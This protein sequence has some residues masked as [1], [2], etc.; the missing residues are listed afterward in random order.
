M[1]LNFKSVSILSLVLMGASAVTAAIIP[2]KPADLRVQGSISQAGTDANVLTCTPTAQINDKACN[3]ST[4]ADSQT[5]QA[6][7]DNSW[8]TVNGVQVQ[9]TGNTTTK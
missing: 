5:T 8:V 7:E 9:T 1:K 4:A 6:G 2:T 3:A